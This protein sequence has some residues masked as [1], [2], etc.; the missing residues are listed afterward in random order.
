MKKKIRIVFILCS[1][2]VILFSAWSLIRSLRP[3]QGKAYERLSVEEASEYMSYESVYCI[4]DVREE[5]A[6]AASHVK[7]AKNVPYG[8]LVESADRMLPDRDM[9][10]Y[11]YGKD[12][13]ESCAAAQKLSD[14]GFTSVTE[15]GS[16]QDWVL[17]GFT[18]QSE[19]NAADPGRQGRIL[20][21]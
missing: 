12:S 14:I 16:Y 2:T 10:L 4:V 9:M 18:D 15:T 5:E 20:A 13:E 21:G 11:V 3:S 1:L 6:Y 7:G 8:K 19:G 17:Y